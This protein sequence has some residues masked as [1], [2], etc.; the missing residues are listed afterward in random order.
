M[1]NMRSGSMLWDEIV[2][3]TQTMRAQ[4]KNVF[5]EEM[6]KTVLTALALKSCFNSIVFQGGTA[7]RL[8][9]GNPRF[10]DDI[11]F[12]LKE[13][14]ES[15]DLSSFL[16][17]IER[18]AHDTFP[19]LDSVEVLTQK[20]ESD[21]QRFILRT[22][23]DSPD[24]SLRVHI[25]L[26]TVQSY[27]NSPKI[28]NFQ[29]LQPAVRVEETLEILADKLCAIAFRPYLKGRDL[30]DIYYLSK[31]RS[32][33]IEWELVHRKVLDNKEII[34]ELG[35]RFDRAKEK[36]MDEGGTILSNELTRFLPKHVLEHYRSSFDLIL[37]SVV[38]LISQYNAELV[39]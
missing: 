11:D 39:G 22:R 32:T 20:N 24:Q 13:G 5:Q 7:L 33:K 35:Q 4:R 9:Y 16:P 31:E 6:Q 12:V 36:I 38:E 23:S 30:W 37:E 10:S 18:F 17:Q 3:K 29:P 14:V 2:E 25:E 34:S 15:Y 26:A 19:F 28:L 21:L 27:R 8:F 1:L